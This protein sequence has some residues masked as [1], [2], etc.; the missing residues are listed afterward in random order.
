MHWYVINTIL[1]TNLKHN[2]CCYEENELHLIQTHYS[3][4]DQKQESVS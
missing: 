3:I 4:E 1:V 2:M